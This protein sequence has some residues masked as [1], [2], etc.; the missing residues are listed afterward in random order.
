MN[1]VSRGGCFAVHVA[2]EELGALAVVVKGRDDKV[3]VETLVEILIDQ[4]DILVDE[5]SVREKLALDARFS[6]SVP[7]NIFDASQLVPGRVFRDKPQRATHEIYHP[8][9]RFFV[10]QLSPGVFVAKHLFDVSR[11]HIG[12]QATQY[13]ASTGVGSHKVEIVEDF[14]AGLI[15]VQVGQHS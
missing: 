3:R 8:K 15:R 10:K 2:A 9:R 4:L 6:G 12:H 14:V 11:V 1:L 5:L 13:Q 7:E